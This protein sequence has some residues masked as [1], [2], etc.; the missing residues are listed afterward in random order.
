[1]EPD[2]WTHPKADARHT[3]AVEA[4]VTQL[5]RERVVETGNVLHS[6]AADRTGV[7]S[8]T[9]G[10]VYAH[11]VD[12]TERWVSGGQFRTLSD[13]PTQVLRGVFPPVVADGTLVSNVF[14]RPSSGGSGPVQAGLYAVSADG[15]RAWTAE[16]WIGA[17]LVGRD[18][19]VYLAGHSSPSLREAD[20]DADRAQDRARVRALDLRS[21]E[22]CWSHDR[23]LLDWDDDPL[24]D[25]TAPIHAALGEDALVVAPAGE[26]LLRFLDP[27]T[28]EVLEDHDVD[29]TVDRPPMLDGTRLYAVDEVSLAGPGSGPAIVAYDVERG[30]V[31]WEYSLEG[32][33]LSYSPGRERF[34]F[35]VGDGVVVGTSHEE[36]VA[37]DAADGSRLWS[38]AP[39][40]NGLAIAGDAL[41]GVEPGSGALVCR[42]L[43][44][45]TERFRSAPP[46]GSF[47]NPVVADGV[48]YVPF[49]DFDRTALALFRL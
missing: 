42:D 28:G 34:P 8:G 17:P 33:P 21:G 18:G 45:G 25:A 15:E 40:R 6:P 43:R 9:G 38:A 10:G 36:T 1:M 14:F 30:A 37:F 49:D 22:E 44:A 3:G 27:E 19:R 39:A 26:R 48:A 29:F 47:Q 5:E 12:G 32:E 4:E 16:S 31:D 7:Y 35:A 46:F 11:D 2:A 41:L 23:G 24:F 13:P 20:P